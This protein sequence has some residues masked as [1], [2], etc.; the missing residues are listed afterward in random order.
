MFLVLWAVTRLRPEKGP[1]TL[2]RVVPR[3]HFASYLPALLLVGLIFHLVVSFYS[4]GL[5]DLGQRGNPASW[6]PTALYFI[7][8]CAAFWTFAAAGAPRQI[9]WLL[10]PAG[11]A[12]VSAAT[13]Y[14]FLGHSS[15]GS[16]LRSVSDILF[17]VQTC[18][19]ALVY[20]R[21]S[22]PLTWEGGTTLA[23]LAA[24]A[25]C[26]ALIGEE[27]VRYVISGA[28]AFGLAWAFMLGLRTK[29]RASGPMS[30]AASTQPETLQRSQARR[31]PG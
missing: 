30:Q 10:L 29:A 1:D 15:P 28:V 31:P 5:D 21:I 2:E 4:A 26:S 25:A 24:A 20:A 16:T 22:R 14:Q 23:L 17:V 3:S 7:I 18:A 11:L 27:A 8:A 13:L 9:G 6:Y 12:L 19:L